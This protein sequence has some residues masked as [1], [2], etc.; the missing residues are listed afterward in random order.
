MARADDAPTPISTKPQ[1]KPGVIPSNKIQVI[2]HLGR[3]RGQV[4][5]LATAATASRF[6]GGRGAMLTKHNGKTVWKGRSH[7]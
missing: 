5:R 7:E 3:P 4:G 1:G 2:D 6:L